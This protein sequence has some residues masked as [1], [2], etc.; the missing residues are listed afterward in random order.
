[1]RTH[2]INKL[3][4]RVHIFVMSSLFL[5]FM[6][7]CNE[8]FDIEIPS[9]K[10]IEINDSTRFSMS[11]F[12]HSLEK[13]FNVHDLWEIKYD[14]QLKDGN[15]EKS[16]LS[17][18]NYNGFADSVIVFNHVK[19]S[20]GVI[21]HSEVTAV[22]VIDEYY[23]Y[24]FDDHDPVKDLET[25]LNFRIDYDYNFNGKITSVVV[26]K[27]DGEST[28]LNYTIDARG[29]YQARTGESIHIGTF[30]HQKGDP[31]Y[32]FRY[33]PDTS[34]YVY[35]SEGN[36]IL[37]SSG[38]FPSIEK[39]HYIYKDGYLK[40]KYEGT[41]A[42]PAYKHCFVYKDHFSNFQFKECD[43]FQFVYNKE[44]NKFDQLIEFD[45]L[46]DLNTQTPISKI[47]KSIWV[48]DSVPVQT[49]SVYSTSGELLFNIHKTG[50]KVTDEEGNV[51][52]SVDDT[53]TDNN[54]NKIDKNKVAQLYTGKKLDFIL[55]DE[56]VDFFQ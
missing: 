52:E 21:T 43:E 10:Y 37:K 42:N 46:A 49:Y 26:T 35:D 11:H 20:Q 44:E 36:L 18:T 16:Y 22:N 33:A 50:Y 9:T 12:Q 24:Y 51:I 31:F 45:D 4:F 38:T 8:D 40:T 30:F 15:V 47:E 34:D 55:S 1:M 39:K 14:H 54:N 17:Y 5:F 6:L 29:G 7:S 2:N 3:L 23:M 48:L 19:N 28:Q 41:Q 27:E 56:F 32:Y 13:L 25:I 53:Y